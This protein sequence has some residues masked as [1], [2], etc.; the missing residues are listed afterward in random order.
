MVLLLPTTIIKII[1]PSFLPFKIS[2]SSLSPYPVREIYIELILLQFVIPA[3][4]EHGN[5]KIALKSLVQI[6]AISAA[7][8]M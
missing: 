8:L 1:L 5:C 7:N 6:W 3:L 2:M 4:I